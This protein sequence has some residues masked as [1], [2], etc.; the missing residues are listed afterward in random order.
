MQSHEA[1]YVDGRGFCQPVDGPSLYDHYKTGQNN[2]QAWPCWHLRY[3][4]LIFR[5]TPGWW[6][7]TFFIFHNI[8]DNPSHWR[9]HIFQR[10][11]YTTNQVF[12]FLLLERLCNHWSVIRLWPNICIPSLKN[13]PRSV[14][15]SH[16]CWHHFRDF[17]TI[18]P[19][20]LV[21]S[22]IHADDRKPVQSLFT[23]LN[24]HFPFCGYPR[25]AGI[26]V[27]LFD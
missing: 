8:W 14:L 9:T 17:L 6:F 7:G 18:Q 21:T 1:G 23:F 15:R 11:R 5:Q 13:S 4:Y 24:Y 26:W 12:I 19:F 2:D 25:Q 22:T 3:W 10:G 16:W 20:L 27:I